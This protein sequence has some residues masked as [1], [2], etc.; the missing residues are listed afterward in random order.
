MARSIG[1]GLR[2]YW[3]WASRLPA[4]K[5]LFSRLL[6]LVVP[7]TGSI[8][9]TVRKMEPGHCVIVLKDHRK[10][11]NHLR[12]VHAIALC[13]LGEMVTGL[14]LLNSLPDKTR[15]ILTNLAISYQ[16]KARGV[17]TASCRCDVPVGN[18]ET[19]HRLTGVIHNSS[20]ELVAEV[21][22]NWLTGPEKVD[23][24]AN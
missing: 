21:V 1:P 7:Y 9:A 20:G 18:Q 12:S 24:H 10:I 11:R 6:G 3:G 2:Y 17:L 19:E 22:A 8:S 5:W 23:G 16:K 14:A 13:N 4:G 15:G